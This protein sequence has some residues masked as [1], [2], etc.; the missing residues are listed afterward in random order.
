MLLRRYFGN[1]FVGPAYKTHCRGLSHCVMLAMEL[2]TARDPVVLLQYAANVA[3]HACTISPAVEK[4]AFLVDLATIMSALLFGLRGVAPR[5]LRAM[6][7]RR[8]AAVG[9][10]AGLATAALRGRHNLVVQLGGLA[11]LLATHRA[12]VRASPPAARAALWRALGAFL[13]YVVC[14]LAAKHGNARAVPF[15]MNPTDASRAALGG[16]TAG[17]LLDWVSVYDIGHL[18]CFA[19]AAAVNP[20][21][22]STKVEESRRGREERKV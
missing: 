12:V 17:A 22:A 9:L 15:L 10:G 2:L 21:R 7:G 13:G 11:T 1:E 6:V 4:A 16:T 5:P 3:F 14:F 8:A 20:I 18:L 19:C